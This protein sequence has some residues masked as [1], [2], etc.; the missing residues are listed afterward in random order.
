M[1]ANS[2]PKSRLLGVTQLAG[3]LF[4]IGIL[5]L[6]VFPWLADQPAMSRQIE[7][8]EKQGIDLGS[9]FY[10]DLEIMGDVEANLE[11]FQEKHPHA[12]WNP[13]SKNQ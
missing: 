6:G 9:M 7:L 10:T 11:A 8:R 3:S 1:E 13:W 5:W 2:S 12:L 4:V